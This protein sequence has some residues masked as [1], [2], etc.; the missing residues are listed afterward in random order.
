[1]IIIQLGPLNPAL[2]DG[3]DWVRPF[4]LLHLLTEADTASETSYNLN[5]PETMGNV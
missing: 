5:I 4:S 3:A 1:M 2:S